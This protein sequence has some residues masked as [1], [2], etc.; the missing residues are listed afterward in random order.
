MEEYKEK[1]DGT[2]DEDEENGDSGDGGRVDKR[3]TKNDK[4][5]IM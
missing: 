4:C 5:R 3:K 1:Y 2:N